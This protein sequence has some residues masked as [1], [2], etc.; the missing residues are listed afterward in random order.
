M[1]PTPYKK[2]DSPGGDE[3]ASW[4]GLTYGWDEET[5]N[6]LGNVKRLMKSILVRNLILGVLEVEFPTCGLFVT[7][8]CY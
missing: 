3:P 5:R 4:G 2:N 6:N 7:K 1:T 8:V